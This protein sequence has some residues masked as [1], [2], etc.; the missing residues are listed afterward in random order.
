MKVEADD[1]PSYV[2]ELFAAE[3]QA[4][5]PS[6][7]VE[8]RVRGKVTITLGAS[9]ATAATA[10]VSVKATWLALG[11]K[12]SVVAV[13]VGAV[14]AAGGI[15]WR[16]HVAERP[17]PAAVTQPVAFHRGV[18]P[19]TAVVS[20]L[21]EV[22]AAVAV[23]PV[24]AEA[25]RPAP[26]ANRPAVRP[27]S[28]VAEVRNAGRDQG[29]LTVESPLIDR[30]RAGIETHDPARALAQLEE[31]KRRFPHGQLEEEREALWVQVLVESGNADRARAQAAEF[32]RRFPRSIQLPIVEAAVSSIE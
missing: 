28:S 13:S 10:S 27:R 3:R 25:A 26:T 9:S 32:R 24:P 12:L 30:A 29:N 2:D 22:P 20:P 19:R 21:P 16:R 14:G 8:R 11:I 17:R 15:A 7:E 1:I 4:P 31:H 18:A 6:I 23:A 5:R